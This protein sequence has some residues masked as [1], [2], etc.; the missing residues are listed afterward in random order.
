VAIF[1][2]YLASKEDITRY[3]LHTIRPSTDDTQRRFFGTAKENNRFDDM[4]RADI[5]GK[6]IRL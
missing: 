4:P 5:R 1:L 3:E 6:G 2:G